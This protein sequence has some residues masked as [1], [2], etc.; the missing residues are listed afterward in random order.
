MVVIRLSRG[1]A[2]KRPFYNVVVADSRRTASGKVFNNQKYTAAHKKLPFGTKLRVTNEANGRSVI[3][4]V[5]DRGPFTRG[6]DI[7]LT[8]KA[9]KEIA[10]TSYGGSL[11]VT[12]EII[13][14]P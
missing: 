12:L 7:D 6:R 3:V 11:K 9:F 10:G 8:R 5:N 14:Q 2:K 1:G 13:Q 4:E